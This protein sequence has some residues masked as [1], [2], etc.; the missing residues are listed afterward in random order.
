MPTPQERREQF[1]AIYGAMSDVG[2]AAALQAEELAENTRRDARTAQEA[3]SRVL[4]GD[5]PGAVK[6][7]RG[8]LEK[9]EARADVVGR[10]LREGSGEGRRDQ[11]AG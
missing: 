4:R 8:L 10:L 11:D 7:L 1:E 6:E 5:S 2:R 3:L 9:M